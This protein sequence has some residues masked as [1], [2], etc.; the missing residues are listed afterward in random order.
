[1]MKRAKKA[2]ARIG[3]L[4][5]AAGA[6]AAFPTLAF[7]E[8][9]EAEASGG[10]NVI[11]PDMLE[12]IPM[13]VAFIVLAIILWKFGWPMFEN[14]LVKREETIKNDLEKAERDRIESEQILS[15][16]KRQLD[17][18][19]NQAAQIVADAKQTGEGVRA[20]LTAKAKDESAALIEKAHA[21][22][23]ADKKTAVAEL[24]ASVADTAVAV[25]SRIIGQDL[26]DDEHRAII[27]RYV[28]EAGSFNAN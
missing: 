13:L 2:S 24:Q 3:V 23:E 4:A 1:M 28:S 26:S 11:L 18:A 15:D 27:A 6:V 12:F 19:K 10:I 8:Q 7:A 9:A 14:M 25:A 5:G 20:D 22:I 16:Y 21:T 17:D